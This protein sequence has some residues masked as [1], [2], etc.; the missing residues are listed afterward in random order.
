MKEPKFLLVFEFGK[1]LPFAIYEQAELVTGARDLFNPLTNQVDSIPTKEVGQRLY[2]AF[3]TFQGALS[4]LGQL[5][6]NEPVLLAYS[7]KPIDNTFKV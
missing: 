3:E 2:D 6:D 7:T 4:C 5:N 1:P